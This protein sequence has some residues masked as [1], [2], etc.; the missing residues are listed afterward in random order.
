[1]LDE[2]FVE[3]TLLWCDPVQ[4]RQ[5]EISEELTASILRVEEKDKKKKTAEKAASWTL[6]PTNHTFS[7]LS[8]RTENKNRVLCGNKSVTYK[9][10]T[11]NARQ[12]YSDGILKNKRACNIHRLR[13]A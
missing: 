12:N 5:P 3:Q 1:M 9:T 6:P 4:F 13:T 8:D 10:H 2:A 11:Y 7:I